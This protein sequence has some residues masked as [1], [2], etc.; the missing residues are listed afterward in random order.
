MTIGVYPAGQMQAP[1]ACAG[2]FPPA[3]NIAAPTAA[4]VKSASPRP[5]C[6]IDQRVESVMAAPR[7][8][9]VLILV[10]PVALGQ[11]GPLQIN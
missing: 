7:T 1:C 8:V 11:M 6:T 4:P 2:E 3:Q 5:N 9:A 10:R